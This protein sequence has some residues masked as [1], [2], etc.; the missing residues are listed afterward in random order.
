MQSTLEDKRKHNLLVEWESMCDPRRLGCQTACCFYEG[1]PCVH[2]KWVDRKEKVGV[3]DIYDRRFEEC[4]VCNEGK[5]RHKTVDG[6]VF[7]VVPMWV[8]LQHVQ[9][10]DRCGYASVR[11]VNGIPVVRGKP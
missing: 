4:I 7:Q 11:S 5:A 8:R 9:A 3:C 6:K 1:S 10:P 2:L